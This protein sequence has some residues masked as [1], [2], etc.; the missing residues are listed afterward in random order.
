MIL[1]IAQPDM[2]MVTWTLWQQWPHTALHVCVLL[3]YFATATERCLVGYKLVLP[4][5]HACVLQL[6][7]CG[8]ENAVMLCLCVL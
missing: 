6:Q 7:A 2:D 5:L 8:A 1:G 3:V 4:A